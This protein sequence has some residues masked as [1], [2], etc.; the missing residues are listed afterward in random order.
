M[1]QALVQRQFAQQAARDAVGPLDIVN[2][3][4]QRCVGAGQC[5]KALLHAAQ[6]AVFGLGGAEFYHRRQGIAQQHA[7]PGQGGTGYSGVWAKQAEQRAAPYRL[8][9]GRQRQH[10]AGALLQRLHKSRAGCVLA[11][12][13]ELATDHVA[14]VAK[15]AALHLVDQRGFTDTRNP[16][17]SDCLNRA[18]GGG[19]EHFQHAA[20]TFGP[21]VQAT[22]H[23]KTF[24]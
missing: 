5:R 2:K 1:L 10:L 11:E 23:L 15:Q 21:A 22:R 19:F 24:R 6:K 3:H 4:H 13:V 17:D 8:L 16:G 12:L 9:I 7:Q 14:T 20:H 18:G